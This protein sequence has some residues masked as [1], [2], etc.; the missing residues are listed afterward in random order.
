MKKEDTSSLPAF[1]DVQTN[2]QRVVQRRSF[3]QGIGVA[4]AAGL[5][6]GRLLAQENK[7]LSQSDAALLRFAA[8][9][10]FI[11]ADLWQQYNELGG[12]VDH[13]DKPNPGNPAYVAALQ[14]LDGDMPQY[15]SDN[16]DDEISHRD[17][18]NAYLTSKGAQP[19][20]FRQFETLRPTSATGALANGRLTN[21]QTLTVDT[22]W[23]FRYRSRKNPDLG[24]KFPQLLN[25]VKQPAIPLHDNNAQSTIQA[26]AN[27]AAIHFAFIEQGGS[28]LYPILALKA[29]DL[30]VLRILLSIGG[31]EIDHFSL[32]HDK[33]GNAVTQPVAPFSDPVTGLTFPDFNNPAN[34]HNAQLSADDQKA[35][36]QLFQTNLIQPEPCEF[37]SPSLPDC[38]IIR[39]TL[40]PNGGP[41]ATVQAFIADRLFFGQNPQFLEQLMD[42]ASAAEAARR[43][44][45]V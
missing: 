23:Y 25:I 28:S 3:L 30:E 5:P 7:G 12:Q 20:D 13:N 14:K 37:L 17:F 44:G 31:V 32:W 1:D 22:S 6:A 19:I 26:I 34:Q 11:E 16:T 45:D 33:M 39:P 18:L 10:E 35:G 24:A 21:L 27:I 9:I 43:E 36:G 29:T 41:T 15:I 2:W 8:A 38:S 42:L 4:G 40:S